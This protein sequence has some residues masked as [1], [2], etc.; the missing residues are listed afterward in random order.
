MNPWIHKV[1]TYKAWFLLLKP[2]LYYYFMNP[3]FINPGFINPGFIQGVPKNP[4]T[5]EITYC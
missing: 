3:D 2:G 4:K 1:W 5:I